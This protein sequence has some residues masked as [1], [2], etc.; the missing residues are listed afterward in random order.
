M[1]PWSPVGMQKLMAEIPTTDSYYDIETI[2]VSLTVE[3]RFKR[4]SVTA[5]N[6][7]IRLATEHHL[8]AGG[9][10]VDGCYGAKSIKAEVQ[11]LP[12]A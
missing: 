2:T 1:R 8:D 5:R 9:V 3:I 11:Q 10:G 12:Q 4:G 6:N 7:A